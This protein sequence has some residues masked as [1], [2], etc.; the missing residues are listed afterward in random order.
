MVIDRAPDRIANVDVDDNE[1]DASLSSLF[2]IIPLLVDDCGCFTINCIAFGI[3]NAV[4]A[5]FIATIF[6]QFH[7]YISFFK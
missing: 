2:F 3:T 1:I 7:I 6:E 4:F 5:L